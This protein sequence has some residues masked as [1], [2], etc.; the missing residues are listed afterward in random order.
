LQKNGHLHGGS[1]RCFFSDPRQVH[2]NRARGNVQRRRNEFCR[3][4]RANLHGNFHFARR[5]V[6]FFARRFHVCKKRPLKNLN[7]RPK[8]ETVMQ[9]WSNQLRPQ[10]KQ[11][12][13]CP[14]PGEQ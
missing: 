7:F 9:K 11:P 6:K 13:L 12:G 2:F 3:I 8:T 10:K 5:E 1:A 14:P 4:A